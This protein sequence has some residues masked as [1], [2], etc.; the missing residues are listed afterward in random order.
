MVARPRPLQRV[1][2]AGLS[3]SVTLF[4]PSAPH[5]DRRGLATTA[6][7]A[8]TASAIVPVC[9][10]MATGCGPDGSPGRA[11]GPSGNPSPDF[12]SRAGRLICAD[13]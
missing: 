7:S 1:G 2:L 10:R 12:L 8:G 13:Q 3:V 11:P 9:M 6:P 4:G 5:T